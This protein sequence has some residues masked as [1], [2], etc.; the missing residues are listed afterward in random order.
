MKK[1]ARK[2]PGRDPAATLAQLLDAAE[3]EFNAR[4]FEGTDTNRIARA[5]GYAPQTFYRHFR[6][7]KAA[8]LAVYDRWWK[9]ESAALES[10]AQERPANVEAAA[11]VA[12]AFH[13]KWRGFRRALRHLA[14]VDAKV[15]SARTKARRAQIARIREFTGGDVRS[16]QEL[17]AALLKAE[18]LTDAAAEGELADLG[19]SPAAAKTLVA[20]AIAELFGSQT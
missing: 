19:L 16:D 6:D 1:A 4:G 18:R 17:I 11:R 10:P 2:K 12:L 5:A 9:D 14:I 7:K 8:F 20:A 13:T 3:R 15:R